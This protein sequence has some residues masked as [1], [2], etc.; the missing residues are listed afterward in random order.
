MFSGFNL[1]EVTMKLYYLLV[2]PTFLVGCASGSGSIAPPATNS[3]VQV[4]SPTTTTTE[5]DNR[6]KL[7]P[8]STTY[9]LTP[10][11]STTV[12]Y[13]TSPYASSSSFP[14][15][16]KY[17]IEDFGFFQATVKGTHG[18]SSVAE[19]GPEAV[20]PG[21]WEQGG[22][23]V[24]A[25]INGDK[26]KDF[27]VF[28]YIQGARD[29]RPNQYI[30][31]FVNDGSGHFTL[32][33]SSTFKTGSACI[34]YGSLMSKTDPNN[35]CGYHKGLV[36]NPLVAD[37]NNDGIDDIYYTSILHLSNQGVLENKS[38]TNLPK[39]LFFNAE[40]F[41]PI[42]THDSYA[43]DVNGDKYLDI[44]VPIEQRAKNGYRADGSKDPCGVACAEKL[45]WTMLMNDGKGNFTANQNFPVFDKDFVTGKPGL[46]ANTAAIADFDGDGHGDVAVGW[47]NPANTQAWNL[48][49]N[50][51]GAVFYNNGK[52]DWRTRT[53]VPLPA[54]WYGANGRANDMEVFDFD[55]DGKIDIV[56]ASTKSDPYYQGRAVQFFKNINGTSFTDV[57]KTAHPNI[58]KY[59]NGNGTA[60]WNGEGIM[61]LKD[62]DHDGDLDIVDQVYNTY[63]LINDGKG[64]FTLYENFPIVGGGP[65]GDH[66]G[67]LYA[68]EIDG[69]YQY[70]FIGFKYDKT[71]DDT[72]VTTYY[73]VLDPPAVTVPSLYDI[74]L[75]DFL[76]K[77]STYTTMA[78][79]ANRAYTDL[80]YYSRWN[81][82][83][84]RVFST[85]NNGVTTVGG[86]FGG[87]DG[88]I[89][90]LNAKSSNIGPTNVFT[91][92]TDAVGLYANKGKMF[93]MVGYSH[94]RLNGSIESD[95]F[96]TARSS[97]TADTFGAELSYKD[98]LGKFSY[99]IGSR[100]N[101]TVVKGFLEQGADVNL[102]VADQH[103]N[104]ANLV[105]TL[106]YFD[107]INY[108]GTRFFYGAD[109][110][111]LRYF[112]S[113]GNDV[114]VS[115]GGTF[116]S[117]KGVNRL[118]KDGTAISLNAGA[119]LN[120]NT[121]VLLSVTNATKDPSYTVAF[122]YRF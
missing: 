8:T 37:F 43:G 36:R 34:D 60:W 15:T 50:S 75:D 81:T 13:G 16:D 114:R 44:F 64:K 109:V 14:K 47:L 116:T 107:W 94:S 80:F 46:Q 32:A 117:V 35:I 2:A 42:F 108:K 119:W 10:H 115:T 49:T 40:A 56:L 51:A 87:K 41:G 38:L 48:G 113:N 90:V 45:P 120:S 11:G 110:E 82:N 54:N 3:S 59:E 121:N 111:Y 67:G 92:D 12:S 95:F 27:Y 97:T 106:G 103:Y 96:G 62:F 21:A 24:E 7:T 73:Q 98:E 55:G 19:A 26:H 83:N 28:E 77:P 74:M 30:H 9:N 105:A 68:V 102:R 70:D 93:A 78:A 66:H 31:A 112:Y 86:T 4:S 63:V 22:Y 69:K 57:T 100:Y 17:K 65:K 25:N 5:V 89:T 33:N 104:S 29:D 88:G 85:Y 1:F 71:S 84:A 52:N 79:M 122:G 76:R 18:G 20:K 53:V 101:S 58:S 99:S 61:V 118:N 72:G 91:G 23:I 39:N 6:K